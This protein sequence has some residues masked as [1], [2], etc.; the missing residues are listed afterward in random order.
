MTKN[1]EIHVAI[2]EAGNPND[3]KPFIISAVLIQDAKSYLSLYEEA[4]K[5]AQILTGKNIKY[6]KW[7]ED[8]PKQYKLGKNVKG[9][10]VN[11]VLKNLR[12]FSL[13]IKKENGIRLSEFSAK[14]YGEIVGLELR[15]YVAGKRITVHYD[16]KPILR[17]SDKQ[18]ILLNFHKWASANVIR[19]YFT[20]HDKCRLIHS[21]DYISGIVREHVMNQLSEEYRKLIEEYFNLIKENFE[22]KEISLKSLN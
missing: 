17:E 8:T 20:G 14:I 15:K 16:R 9:I 5:D 10:F 7:S 2:D 1:E 21:E 11:K 18:Y 19:V 22:I 13:I 4:I 6:F 3:E 12:G